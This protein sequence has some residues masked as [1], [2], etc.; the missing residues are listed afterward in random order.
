M[1]VSVLWPLLTVSLVG[2]QCVIVVFPAHN[3][4]RFCMGCSAMCSVQVCCLCR[5]KLAYLSKCHNGLGSEI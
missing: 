2:M 4:R 1:I 3:H 5:C